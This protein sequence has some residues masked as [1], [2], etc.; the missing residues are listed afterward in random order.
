MAFF[1]ALTPAVHADDAA[2]GGLPL[3][4]QN[5]FVLGSGL[6]AA[7]S[8]PARGGWLVDATLDIANTELAQAGGTS[9]LL[10][11]AETRST[12]VAVAWAFDNRW[13]LRASISHFAISAGFLDGAVEDFHRAFGF[14]NGDR[15]QL[16]TQAPIIVVRDDGRALYALDRTRSGLGPTLVD[17]TRV[18]R[19]PAG[20]QSG[21]S[22]GLKLATGSESRFSDTGST[23]LSLA[24]FTQRR[25]GERWTMAAR[26]GVLY[27]HDN[28][29]LGDRAR[30]LVP[31][32]GAMLG[33]RLGERWSAIVQADAHGA[34][35]RDLPDFLAAANTLSVGLSRRF[36]ERGALS[37]TLGEDL[38]ALHTTDVVL[39]LGWRFASGD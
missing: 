2:P 29:L 32:A 15:D 26:A 22:F 27:Q 11:D 13:S 34:L 21:L 9:S 7:P 36:G 24:A 28:A 20:T 4:D 1:L 19:G 37:V 35:Y 25:L 8:V 38:P 16:G 23:D 10:F 3:R 31:F 6:P 17:L 14:D 5:P 12:R 18:W 30:E 33:Y 39:G